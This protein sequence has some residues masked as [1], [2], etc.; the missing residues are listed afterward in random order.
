MPETLSIFFSD[1]EGKRTCG[2][3]PRRGGRVRGRWYYRVDC[4]RRLPQPLKYV[5]PLVNGLTAGCWCSIV[6]APISLNSKDRAISLTEPVFDLCC[7]LGLDNFRCQTGV[8]LHSSILSYYCCG[9]EFTCV[10]CMESLG[11][12][13]RYVCPWDFETTTQIL[14]I[15]PEGEEGG[16]VK[17]RKTASR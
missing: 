14:Q 13:D 11:C 4:G 10:N 9:E 2:A 16:H 8:D 15:F 1:R 12:I 7:F 3:S 5:C 17:G 6:L